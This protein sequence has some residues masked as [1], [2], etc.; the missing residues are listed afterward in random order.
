MLKTSAYGLGFQHLPRDL[1]N[2]NACKTMFDP[3]INN[4]LSTSHFTLILS[5]LVTFDK[6]KSKFEKKNVCV[7]VGGGEG[8]GTLTPKLYN[9]MPNCVS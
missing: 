9:C 3:Y 4:L 5:S 2:V 1:A 8:G 7:C 6:G